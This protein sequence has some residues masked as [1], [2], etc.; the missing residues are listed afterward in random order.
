[1]VDKL[2]SRFDNGLCLAG[3]RRAGDEEQDTAVVL[4]LDRIY[5]SL[6]R[7]ESQPAA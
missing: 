3:S 7:H 2:Q 4:V 5:R 6:G 1:M